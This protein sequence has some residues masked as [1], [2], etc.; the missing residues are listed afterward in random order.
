[1]FKKILPATPE[2]ASKSSVS[3]PPP[4]S[5]STS[6]KATKMSTMKAEEDDQVSPSPQICLTNHGKYSNVNDD[7]SYDDVP[8][9]IL[10]PPSPSQIAILSNATIDQIPS[11]GVNLRAHTRDD[12]LE[13]TVSQSMDLASFIKSLELQHGDNQEQLQKEEQKKQV[14]LDQE[15]RAPKLPINVCD[16]SLAGSLSLAASQVDISLAED[17]QVES[18]AFETECKTNDDDSSDTNKTTENK[19][20]NKT[21]SKI[22]V[23]EKTTDH[24]SSTSVKNDTQNSD[25]MA[26][27]GEVLFRDGL[28]SE[29]ESNEPKTNKTIE[30]NG[31]PEQKT[32][33]TKSVGNQISKMLV[34]ICLVLVIT[35]FALRSQ[36]ETKTEDTTKPVTPTTGH[37]FMLRDFGVPS[38]SAVDS[39]RTIEADQNLSGISNYIVEE[40]N[41]LPNSTETIAHASN[42]PTDESSSD[43]PFE[44]QMNDGT[45]EKLDISKP[46]NDSSHGWKIF[47]FLNAWPLALVF[48]AYR[49]FSSPRFW[50]VSSSFPNK[51]MKV[52]METKTPRTPTGASSRLKRDR[53]LTPPPSCESNVREPTKWMSPCYG[54]DAIDIS[55]YKAMKHDELRKLLRERNCDA[56]GK[57]EQLIK[58]LVMSYQNELACLT[59]QKLRP[60][61]RRRNL[62][63]KGTKKDIVRRLV[64]A[65]PHM[66][67]KV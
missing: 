40:L 44:D 63:L 18:D 4:P 33:A 30:V 67:A 66:P 28:K 19:P 6:P 2:V 32:P 45:N 64:E 43:L 13:T 7:D 48:A 61:L 21:D 11:S 14:E 58:M 62:S 49:L 27:V 54:D 42:F 25:G 56:R 24:S 46:S 16:A 41:E 8:D 5:A 60:K 15:K 26:N 55:V 37:D 59:V 17:V 36:G 3:S 20:K 29:K 52:K 22:V 47:I 53:F 38:Q 9:L 35:F 34:N 39:F 51:K 50:F 12:S 57:K 1:M 23:T 10:P 31:T 65:G